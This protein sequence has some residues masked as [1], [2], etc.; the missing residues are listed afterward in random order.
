VAFVL[1]LLVCS[2]GHRALQASAAPVPARNLISNGD[3]SRG[4]AP[5]GVHAVG[6]TNSEQPPQPRLADGALCTTVHGGE[7]IVVGWPVSGS[8]EAFALVAGERYE[9]SLRVAAP[10]PLP[11]ECVI[12]VGH[13]LAPYTAAF[14][15]RLPAG[16]T[17]EPFSIAFAPDHVDDRAG[18][19]LECRAA[20]GSTVADVCIDDVRLTTAR[21]QPGG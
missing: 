2:C 4:V 19:A 14:A 8:A 21:G 9:L 11:V 15:T 3:F 5:W 6:G 20:P 12:K 1:A 7:E 13:Q 17:L 10:G 18:I 16:E